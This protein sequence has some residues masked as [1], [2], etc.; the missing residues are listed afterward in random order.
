MSPDANRPGYDVLIGVSGESPQYGILGEIAGRKVAIDLEPDAHHQPLWRSRWREVIHPRRP[1]PRWLRCPSRTSIACRT[2]SRRSSSTTARRWTT[3]PSSPP[4]SRP[5][6]TGQLEALR[7]RYGA[8]PRALTDVLLLVPADK[9]D[10]RRAEY[11]GIEVR[12]L[13]FAAAE[14]QASHWRFLMGAVGNQATYMR[15]V[16]RLMKQLRND[17]TLDEPAP[18][19][20]TMSRLPD[21][22][23]DMATHAPRPRGGVH[24]R[25][26]PLE[27]TYPPWPADHCR[28]A[29]RVHR[30]G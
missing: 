13:K 21:H 22:L 29:R 8:E 24:R 6:P 5:T 2:R 23:K 28:P 26:H 1:S 15:Q 18:G 20:S 25:Q 7:E 12:P 17:L 4:W 19:H 30:E 11:P 9:L 3:G 27:R 14:L 16:N 10:E